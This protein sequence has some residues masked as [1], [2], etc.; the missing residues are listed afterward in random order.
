VSFPIVVR[1]KEVSRALSLRYFVITKIGSD[2]IKKNN[3][4]PRSSV[5]GITTRQYTRQG[6][7]TLPEG[8]FSFCIKLVVLEDYKICRIIAHIFNGVSQT[9]LYEQRKTVCSLVKAQLLKGLHEA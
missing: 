3:Q 7:G 1:L 4:Q 5:L 2:R 9:F 8:K 6:R